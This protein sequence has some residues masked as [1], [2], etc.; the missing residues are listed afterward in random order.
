MPLITS[1]AL[2]WSFRQLQAGKHSV[3]R[4][5]DSFYK[6]MY[7]LI[8]VILVVIMISVQLIPLLVGSVLF[9][10]VVANGIAVNAFEIG[11]WA[12]VLIAT[13]FWSLRMITAS[14]FA[15]YIV[16]LPD[17]TPMRALRSAKNLVEYRRL[18]V[19][20]KVLFLPLLIMIPLGTIVLATIA[21][22]PVLAQWVF[23]A[24]SILILPVVHAYMYTLYRELLSE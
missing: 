12:A 2:I 20:R 14:I 21:I 11:I 7:P 15:V 24:L 23:F 9:S 18:V 22:V 10:L 6:G 4:V 1:L 5:R 16:S 17:M 19:L 3:L 8:P 13:A